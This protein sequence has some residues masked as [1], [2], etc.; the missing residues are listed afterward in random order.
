[1][2]SKGEARPWYKK[3]LNENKVYKIVKVFYI[4]NIALQTRSIRHDTQKLHTVFDFSLKTE[5]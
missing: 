2:C 1:M 5:S 4:I 3:A